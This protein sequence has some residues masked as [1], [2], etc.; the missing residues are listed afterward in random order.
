MR[1]AAPLKES[2]LIDALITGATSGIGREMARLLA[3]RCR[4]LV[5]VGR[6]PARMEA[7]EKELKSYPGLETSGVLA[8]L[9]DPAACVA[10]HRDH[11][12]VDLLINCAG[13]GDYGEFFATSLEKDLAMI[14]T[15]VK[16]L[17]VLTK[18]YL[19][20]MV[21]ADRGHIL[22]VAS[23]AGF[24]PGPL[25][26]TYYATKN[27][28]VRLCE[29]IRKELSKRRS[30]VKISVLC[31]GPVKTGFE[32]AAN[33]GFFFTGSDP[34]YVARYALSHL[35]RFYIVP[36]LAVRAAKMALKL[37]P[38]PAVASAIYMLQSTKK[39]RR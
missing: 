3:P 21:K 10:L 39:I 28:V 15:N 35:D 24:M 36:N 12:G 5:L 33:I 16:A 38:V 22:N 23:I 6:D 31:P 7:L 18:L 9:S 13:F 29:A 20:D 2:D 25:M 19:A 4:R 11:P 1:S 27:Y 8:D 30:K 17:H 34:A 14:D 37:L 26:A 32:K